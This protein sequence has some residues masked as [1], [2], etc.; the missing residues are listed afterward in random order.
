MS[1]FEKVSRVF[2]ASDGKEQ[3][4]SPAFQY[5]DSHLPT[6]WLLGK[7]G[8]GKST[9]VQSITGNTQAEIGK[10]FQPCTQTSTKFGFPMVKPVLHSVSTKP[11]LSR[12]LEQA[13]RAQNIGIYECIGPTD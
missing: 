12:R 4:L 1:L 10:G 5:H 11:D 9:L 6:L 2:Q 8:A 3:T 13:V 7:T